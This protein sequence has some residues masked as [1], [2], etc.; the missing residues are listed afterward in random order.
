MSDW[1]VG[2]DIGATGAI[3]ALD[4][5]ESHAEVWDM[6]T[7]MQ[8]RKS[9]DRQESIYDLATLFNILARYNGAEGVCEQPF[10]N[11][12]GDSVAKLFYGAAVIDV[13]AELNNVRLTKVAPQTW[14]AYMLYRYGGKGATQAE[15]CEAARDHFPTLW[16]LFRIAAHNG[17]AD[18]A[19]QLYYK[20]IGC[21]EVPRNKRG[22]QQRQ[23]N[24]MIVKS[25]SLNGGPRQMC[26][27]V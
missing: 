8:D 24:P 3:F 2:I 4:L 23:L 13:L 18:A 20:L 6:P 16:Q 1:Q 12:F 21:P 19:N 10:A 17:R 14:K 11:K 25:Y 22:V 5:D 9:I 15:K 7:Y 26:L 27:E